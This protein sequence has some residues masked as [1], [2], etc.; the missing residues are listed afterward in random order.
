MTVQPLGI[1]LEVQPGQTVFEAATAAGY[2]WPTVCG[3]QGTCHMC[4]MQ[5][6]QGEDQL[7]VVGPWEAEG[8]EE[9]GNVGDAGECRL[10]CQA[11]V[12]GD[13]TVLKRG[14]RLRGPVNSHRKE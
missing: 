12:H 4:F 9:I 14:V 2:K 10:A 13:V 5:V 11:R 1:E 8:L 7:D 6:L 3:G